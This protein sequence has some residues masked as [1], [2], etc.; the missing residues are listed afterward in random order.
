MIFDREEG[1]QITRPHSAGI[2]E[3][4]PANIP[5]MQLVVDTVKGTY[6]ITDPLTDDE[7]MCE[8]IKKALNRQGLYRTDTKIRG[9]PDSGGKLGPDHMK[10]LVREMCRLVNSGEA[11]VIRGVL[12]TEDDLENM[13]GEFLTN[14]VNMGGWVQPRYERDIPSWVE[15][16]NRLR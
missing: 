8:K 3:G 13:P 10:T 11:V 4:L 6:S 7:D 9:V 14:P 5:G 1:V 12:P 2:I 15:T 16:L